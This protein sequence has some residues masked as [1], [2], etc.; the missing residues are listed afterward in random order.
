M[1]CFNEAGEV[2]LPIEEGVLKKEDI[3]G[4]LAELCKAEVKGRENDSEITLFKSV[5]S[6]LSD[7]VGANHAFQ[8]LLKSQKFKKNM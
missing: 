1:N 4:E 5:G 7:L 8:S 3:K 6:A 2:L